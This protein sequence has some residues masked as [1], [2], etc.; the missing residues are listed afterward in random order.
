MQGGATSPLVC[1]SGGRKNNLI[2]TCTATTAI[3]GNRFWCVDA[4]Q[5]EPASTCATVTR[6]PGRLSAKHT[7]PPVGGCLHQRHHKPKPEP[8][9]T[10]NQVHCTRGPT[11]SGSVD[12]TKDASSTKDDTPSLQ[13]HSKQE[14]WSIHSQLPVDALTPSSGTQVMKHPASLQA[15]WPLECKGGHTNTSPCHWQQLLQAVSLH[16]YRQCQAVWPS[17]GPLNSG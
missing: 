1:V 2:C 15:A 4:W 17:V 8:P 5:A 13:N 9:P 10:A 16:K 6:Q 12:R 3:A 11:N 14:T 7:N